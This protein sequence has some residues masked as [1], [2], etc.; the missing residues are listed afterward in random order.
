MAIIAPYTYG[1]S[2]GRNVSCS[3]KKMEFLCLYH[4][5]F[6][7]FSSSSKAIFFLCISPRTNEVI[8]M[9]N[10]IMAGIK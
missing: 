3:D 4:E 8:N 6:Q 1:A 5:P 10:E 9:V 2:T 7:S